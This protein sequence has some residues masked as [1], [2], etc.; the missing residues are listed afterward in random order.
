MTAL[1]KDHCIQFGDRKC[2]FVLW[3]YSLQKFNFDL[4]LLGYLR[5]F[6]YTLFNSYY[7]NIK[8]GGNYAPISKKHF[9]REPKCFKIS[10]RTFN[11]IFNYSWEADHSKEKRE[12]FMFRHY[13]CDRLNR[14]SSFIFQCLKA[15]LDCIVH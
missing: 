8:N 4:Y 15:P 1:Y 10:I 13:F 12:D 2:I 7:F 6:V 14:I 3:Y 9:L 11:L 5:K